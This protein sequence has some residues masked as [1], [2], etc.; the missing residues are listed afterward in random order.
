MFGYKNYKNYKSI[1][2]WTIDAI[3]HTE[4]FL[5]ATTDAGFDAADFCKKIS[6]NIIL[7]IYL[8]SQIL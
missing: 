3:G 5:D 8:I 2:I 6:Q 7:F 1:K 4:F